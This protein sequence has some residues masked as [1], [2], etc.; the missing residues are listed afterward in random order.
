MADLRFMTFSFLFTVCLMA[1]GC[2]GEVVQAD[3][4]TVSSVDVTQDTQ[5]P[6][7]DS[8]TPNP[9]DVSDDTGLPP[10]PDTATPT[11][12]TATP[13]PDGVKPAGTGT[14]TLEFQ[15]TDGLT[16]PL[17]LNAP[18]KTGDGTAFTVTRLQYWVSNILIQRDDGTDYTV[19]A[20]Y[21][22]MEE[23]VDKK[24]LEVAIAGVPPGTYVGITWSMGVDEAHNHSLDVIEGEL[25]SNVD[26]SWNWNSGY[27]FFKCEGGYDAGGSPFKMHVGTDANYR[28]VT[29][30]FASPVTIDADHPV[31]IIA[32]ADVP[33][34]FDNLP[35]G[36]P[37]IV[38]SPLAKTVADNYQAWFSDVEVVAQ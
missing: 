4:D 36:A 17:E 31:R 37:S 5:D 13:T 34:I 14:L 29:R 28:V 26:M 19:P 6:D 12:D 10:T 38:F 3:A 35:A 23:S 30:A 24:R 2:A 32:K 22:L 16:L 20:S 25:S 18:L 9:T 33:R 27:I 11:P 15:H 1:S 7:Q 8:G 21:Y